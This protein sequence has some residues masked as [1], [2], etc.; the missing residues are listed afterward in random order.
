M[1]EKHE[2]IVLGGGIAGLS[3]GYVLSRAGV[4]LVVCEKDSV[5]GGLSRTIV[6]DGYRFDLGGHRFFTKDPA[7][8]AFVKELMGMEF[9]VA[10]RS[11]KIYF[12]GKYFDY[13]LKPFNALFG[14]GIAATV[15]I[16]TDYLVERAKN[17]VRKPRIVS[18]EDW[19]VNRF[20]R[21]MFE[22]YFKE[23]SEKVWGLRCDRISEEWVAQRIKGLSLWVAIKEAIHKSGDQKI[24]TLA[25]KFLYP[26]LGIGRI[27]DRLRDE[28]DKVN[29]VLT[30]TRV[31]R[32][33]HNGRRIEAVT[34]LTPEG[35]MTLAAQ[36]FISSIPVTSLVRMLR[37]RPPQ[38]VLE[39]AGRLRYR[40]TIIVAVMVDKERVTDLTWIYV[41]ER[42]IPF[43]R[44]H[45]P[46]NWSPKMAPPD[47]TIL[48][49]EYFCFA[50]DETWQ[51]SDE[52]L[53]RT[54]VRYLEELGFVE[55]EEVLDTCV[56]RVKKAYPLLEV[57][58]RESYAKITAYLG[59]FS[60][61]QVIGRTGMFRYHNMDHAID[62]GIKAAE[63]ILGKSHDILKINS[64]REYL[65]EVCRR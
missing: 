16:I 61:L 53:A 2:V 39:A 4:D 34:T 1:K 43:G 9:I 47:K 28:I 22:L 5:V 12:R 36:E 63:N 37:P 10:P 6:H 20:G 25:E 15:G 21:R 7:L 58:Y 35:E 23:Y 27:P 17:L 30:N 19:V 18:L 32:V 60:N 26:E 56:V 64:S 24:A 48:V 13:P 3:A 51:S 33:Q 62:T 29:A 57:G 11:S 52:E 40:D 49:T 31:T 59:G 50:G 45:E 41:P 14:M 42:R 65:E 54:T 38:D 46:K 8:E 44:I 55:R